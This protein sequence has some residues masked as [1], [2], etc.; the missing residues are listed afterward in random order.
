V[1]IGLVFLACV[2]TVPLA[3]GRLAALSELRF[4]A[5]GLLVAAILAQV[6]IVSIFPQGSATFHNAVHIATYVAVAVFVVRNRRIPWVWLVALG[7]ALNFT[8]IAANGGVMPASPRAL[9]NAG[10]AL[11]PAGFTNSGA[12]AHP[13]LQFLGDVFWVPSSFPVSNVFSVG[14]LL[15]LVGAL[16]AMHCIGASRLALRRFAVPAV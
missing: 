14:D 16:L 10:F 7:G 9:Q 13:Q 11:D 15:I 5:S 4:R 1:L 12:V 8:A 6:L 2:A 3:G